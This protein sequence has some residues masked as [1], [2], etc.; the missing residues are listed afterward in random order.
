MEQIWRRGEFVI[1]T[2]PE[3]VDVGTVHRYLSTESYWAQNCSQES[4]VR[5][6][7]GS[8]PFGI[9]HEP[10]GE[11]VGFA[12]VITDQATFSYLTDVFV[13]TPWRGLGLSKWL[14][15]VIWTH[16][17]LQG[18]R[19]WLLATE[20]AHGLYASFGF[21]PVPFP[22]RWMERKPGNWES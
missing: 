12:R 3:R 16:P 8:L 10:T 6:I 17:D 15:E 4:V 7:Q 21:A 20:D 19:R 13:L 14:M 18:Q 9:Y 5:A 1:S 22:E 11:M 2:D